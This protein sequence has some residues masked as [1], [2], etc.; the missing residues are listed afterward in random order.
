MEKAV[1]THRISGLFFSQSRFLRGGAQFWP[2]LGI[3]N[4]GCFLGWQSACTSRMVAVSK[5]IFYIFVSVLQDLQKGHGG[6]WGHMVSSPQQ[7]SPW[8]WPHRNF[9]STP[10]STPD[11]QLSTVL[12]LQ[13]PYWGALQGEFSQQDPRTHSK[14]VNYCICLTEGK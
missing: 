4:F 13:V 12:H 14:C 7:H 5:L 10:L 1:L 3:K 6:G 2:D 11:P 8:S 9:C